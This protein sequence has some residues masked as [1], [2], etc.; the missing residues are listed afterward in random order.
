MN[1]FKPSSTSTSKEYISQC[2]PL[3]QESIK[4]LDKLIREVV[5]DLK[6]HFATNM[7]GYGSFPYKNYKGELVEW[8]TV[9][10]ANQKNYLSLYVC[11][12]DGNQYIAEK[13]AD[14]LGRVKVGKSC[15]RFKQFS[16]LDT[17]TL[18]KV[19]KEAAANPGFGER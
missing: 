3:R 17:D 4:Q 1:M 8:P 16:D 9:A 2:P 13:Y 7:L 14:A 11:A 12:L 19:L 5:P 18:R 15:I 6:P 10:L